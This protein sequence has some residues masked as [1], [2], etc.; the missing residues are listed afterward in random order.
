MV[1]PQA[2]Y[3]N[4]IRF[5][6]KLFAYIIFPYFTTKNDGTGLGLSLSAKII[7]D[8]R[9]SITIESTKGHGTTVTIT[10]PA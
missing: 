2:I 3:K 4:S 1:S 8:H 9:G 7:E 5:Q 10:L 6:I